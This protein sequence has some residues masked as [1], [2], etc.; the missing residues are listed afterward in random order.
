MLETRKVEATLG[1]HTVRIKVKQGCPQGG[2][3][4]PLLWCILVDSL[5]RRLN[6]RDYYC[7]FY[8]DDGVI[9]IIGIDLGTVC[10]V[11]Q[12]AFRNLERWCTEMKLSVAPHKLEL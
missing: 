5:L 12:A 11:M 6:G 2:V 3:L 10:D 4:S 8:S 7:Q 1:G 9:V